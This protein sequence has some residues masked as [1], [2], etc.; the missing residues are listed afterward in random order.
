MKYWTLVTALLISP[1]VLA[2][3]GGIDSTG[4]HYNRTTGEYHC[5]RSGCA[6]K[7]AATVSAVDQSEAALQEARRE[8]RPFSLVYKRQD[9]PHWIDAD[10]DCQDTRAELLIVNS[11]RPVRFRNEKQCSVVEG[12]WY[13]PYSGKTLTKASDL[14]IDHI[15][16]LKW[17]HSHGAANWSKSQK[18][19]FA[20]DPANLI[21]VDDHLNQAK[22]DKGPSEWMPPNQSYRC[23][24]LGRFTAVVAEYGLQP[25][26]TERRVMERMGAA[27]RR[28]IDD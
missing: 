22:S 1:M 10:R 7:G 16:P 26:A 11:Q 27:C 9:W 2:H 25:T 6:G 8:H 28:K 14:D 23:E 12:Q 5:H 15:V 24:Y 3:P 4:G 21:P 19:T 13:D 18:R 17:A 20:N